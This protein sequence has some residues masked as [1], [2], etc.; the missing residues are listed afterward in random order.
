M[1][2]TVR[3]TCAACW[4]F[5][6]ARFS[7]NKRCYSYSN[8]SCSHSSKMASSRFWMREAQ[9]LR[10]MKGC[11]GRVRACNTGDRSMTP[12]ALCNVSDRRARG[13]RWPEGNELDSGRSRVRMEMNV[14][15]AAVVSS[16]HRACVPENSVASTEHTH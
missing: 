14:R 11:F 9:F 5:G 4:S 6:V 2:V 13:A 1:V 16:G 3:T 10:L 15:C 8:C 12:A 7:R